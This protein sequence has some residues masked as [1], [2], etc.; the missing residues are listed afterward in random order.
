VDDDYRLR[1]LITIK[2]IDKAIEIPRRAKDVQGRLI[3]GASLGISADTDKA[4]GSPRGTRCG[5]DR[6]R[7]RARSL[8]QR[9]RTS[10]ADQAEPPGPAVIAANVATGEATR[11]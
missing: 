1:G 9:D 2:D 11:R 8:A 7:F 6:R 3:V 10:A 4:A 5:R